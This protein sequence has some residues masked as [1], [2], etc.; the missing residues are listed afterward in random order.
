VYLRTVHAMD[1]LQ[2]VNLL[3]GGRKIFPNLKFHA[4]EGAAEGQRL[5]TKPFCMVAWFR[6]ISCG[7]DALSRASQAAK[8]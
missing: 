2:Q 7:A 6:G 8:V 5:V 1:G 3:P 4:N